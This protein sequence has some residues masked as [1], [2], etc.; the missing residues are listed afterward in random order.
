MYLEF[1]FEV[2]GIALRI[3]ADHVVICGFELAHGNR[4]L[5]AQTRLQDGV[6]DEDVLLLRE[7]T[8]LCVY[9]EPANIE[10]D[11]YFICK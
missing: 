11:E 3:D 7:E 1:I 10:Y 5:A 6:V 2:R 8:R 9:T 4:R